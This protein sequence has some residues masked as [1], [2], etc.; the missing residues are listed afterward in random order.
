MEWSHRARSFG[1]FILSIFIV[2]H[3]VGVAIV[4]P[5]DKSYM[6]DGLMKVY[7]PY[8]A[9]FH[10]NQSWPFYAPNPFLGSLLNYQTVSSSGETKTYPLTQARAKFDHAY[11]R[12]T[13]FYAY[14]FSDP[15]YSR[16]QGYDKSVAHYLCRQHQNEDVVSINF[17]LLNQQKFTHEDYKAG[18]RPLDKEFLHETIF[19]PYQCNSSAGSNS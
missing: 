3:A 7:Q 16:N 6:R 11:F 17:I 1:F 12:Y 4:G 13:N 18:K 5:F 10:L 2:W 8:L 14:L 15:N 9:T 19:G